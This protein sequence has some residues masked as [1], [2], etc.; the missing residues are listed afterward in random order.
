MSTEVGS[1]YVTILPSGR[2]F[3]RMLAKELG[4]LRVKVQV[5]PDV[6][7]GLANIRRRYRQESERT[8]D[9]AGRGFAARFGRS[10]S[11]GVGDSFQ[12]VIGAGLA[13]SLIKVGAAVSASS[14]AGGSLAALTSGLVAFT[15]AVGPAVGAAAALPAA[16]AAVGQGALVAKVGLLGLDDA[17]KGQK[18]ALGKLAPSARQFVGALKA[19]TPAAKSVQRAIQQELFQGLGVE[20]RRLAKNYLPIL[21]AEGA[22]TAGALQLLAKHASAM[23]NSPGFRRDF[24]TVLSANSGHLVHFGQAGLNLVTI[25]RHLAVAVQPLVGRF[26]VFLESATGKL[27]HLVTVARS[28]GELTR[29]FTKAGD[30]AAQLGRII[31]NVAVAVG[32]FFSAGSTQGKGLLDSLEHASQKF[33]DFTGSQ[34]GAQ[35]MIRFFE[36]GRT[37]LQAFGRLLADAGRLFG[38]S[39]SAVDLAPLIDQVRVQLLP[40]VDQLLTNLQT[41]QA[42]PK[43]VQAVSDLVAVAASSGGALSAFATSLS[44]IASAARTIVE[45]VPGAGAAL[46]VLAAAAGVNAAAKVVGLG[47]ALDVVSGKAGKLGQK[48]GGQLLGQV[49][50]F[51]AGFTDSRV[52]ASAFSGVAGTI[53]G[54]A[55]TIASALG[56]A[57][58]AVGGFVANAARIVAAKAAA[59][60]MTALSLA[61]RGL[62]I[63]IRFMTGPIGIAIT[64]AAALAAAA[65]YAYQHFAPFRDA[66][67]QIGA[68][69]L[70]FGRTIVSGAVAAFHF[71]ASAAMAAWSGIKAGFAVLTSI[72][73]AVLPVA[74]RIADAITQ[75]LQGVIQIVKGIV[76]TIVGIFTLDMGRVTTGLANIFGGVVRMF[77]G[78]PARIVGAL[79][80]LTPKVLAVGARAMSALGSAISRGITATVAFFRSLPGRAASAAAALGARLMAL[81]RRALSAM[82][83]AM[84]S[85]ASAV[86]AFLR[87]LPGR[88]ASSAS[89]LGS[90]LASVGSR[91]LS[92]MAHAISS[93]A[94]AVFSFF[95]S[96]PGRVVSALGNLGGLLVGVGQD[97]IRGLINGVKSMAG[98]VASAARETVSKAISAAKSA[99]GI[100]SPSKVFKR[101]G[102]DT[103][104]GLV[105]G[106]TGGQKQIRTASE[107]MVKIL[108]EGLSG[109]RESRAVN[110]IRRETADLNRLAAARDQIA[111]KL[112]VATS[113]LNALRSAS[114]KVS[115]DIRSGIM[116]SG[117]ITDASDGFGVVSVEAMMAKL[118]TSVGAAKTFARNIAALRQRG[119]RSD[120]L[121]QLGEAGVAQ[122]GAAAQA[123]AA[124]SK[125]QLAKINGLQ[126]QLAA[127]AAAT[128]NT[129]SAAMY[130]A[131][132]RAAEGMV[133]GLMSQRSNIG[134]AMVAIASAMKTAIKRALG[135]HSPS[136]VM[137]D[138]F[139][140]AAA[141]AAVGLHRGRG[142]VIDAADRLASSIL[143]PV[144]SPTFGASLSA[145]APAA[146]PIGSP[147]N[148]P[149][150]PSAGMDEV[151][152]ANKTA[153]RL[154]FAVT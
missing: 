128:G 56:S 72:V 44:L 79:I 17:I 4:E 94:S 86:W 150:Y 93:A 66:V 65:V 144:Q 129:V 75:P 137:A 48:L 146:A 2:G 10:A 71:L 78:L 70:A 90:R 58:K 36:V 28:S 122:G 43:L 149:I 118:S 15:S 49:K 42:L 50:L 54:K 138:L 6:D 33:R 135:I 45:H 22:Q 105:I 143:G 124:A 103:I 100:G 7:E 99:L 114:A 154:A 110:L 19:V 102:H 131:S 96:L 20:V 29:F 84:R 46:G 38:D 69:L 53:G 60:A 74:L 104:R 85:A 98:N 101:I 81:G 106:L 26:S 14:V 47:G 153:R 13:K 51:A 83:S 55:A 16:Y 35:A 132:I 152:L 23:A 3:K 111:K 27:A 80:T 148:M 95:R 73:A 30:T 136:T 133:R 127:A 116:Q 32:R 24:A 12:R 89:A 142:D 112:K 108:R 21:R 130:S 76:Q 77:L 117:T 140:Q 63:A 39:F 123:L 145:P 41:S 68:A 121:Q 147:I 8:G 113:Q 92:A 125:A 59:G 88:A 57:G 141:G 109:V 120:L 82:A 40:A 18:G 64:V 115:A 5:D 67:N 107:K 87:S 37:N 134:R 52:A 31:G 97:L 91:A 11:S 34:A 119:L 61:A 25:F 139:A 62:G 126:G 1:A 9:A 151:D